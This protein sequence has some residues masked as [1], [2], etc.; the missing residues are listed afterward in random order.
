MLSQFIDRTRDLGFIGMGFSIPGKPLYFE[1]FSSWLSDHKNADMSWLERNIELREDPTKLLP[2]CRTIISLAFP[3]SSQKPVTPDGYSVSRYSQPG[4]KDYHY[5]LKGL[6]S[7]LADMVNEI[8]IGSRTR[9]CVDSAPILEKSFA[10]SSGIGF[11]G[12]NN[13]LIMP[14]YGSYFYLAEILITE[15]LEFPQVE[16]M[17]NR[18]GSC[19]LCVDSCPTGALEKPFYLDASRCLSYL[20]IEQT[21]AVNRE[22]GRKM[23]DC[24][25]GCDRCQEVCPFNSDEASRQVILP[26][27]D[28]FLGMGNHYFKERFGNTA[29]A[30]AGIEKI[31][32]NILAIKG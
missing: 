18:C 16:P 10:C 23:G 11:M 22:D 30:R 15:P 29:F 9:I 32:T 1:R 5:R 19:T 27:T 7:E 12:K 25:F 17:E 13:M 21:E 14:G 28:E 24:F 20:T 6:C 8:H 3:Y 31:K 26:S 2:G 4:E